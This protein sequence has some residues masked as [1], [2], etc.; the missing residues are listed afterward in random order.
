MIIQV[1]KVSENSGFC[2]EYFK[3]IENGN[4]YA[5]QEEFGGVFKWYTTTKQGEPNSPLR[6]D[7]TIEIVGNWED[8]QARQEAE[9]DK[10]L[11]EIRS[12]V[13]K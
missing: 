3:N 1:K 2:R 4:V 10:L 7:I 13:S 12:K 6:D 8:E 9:F 11:E 5:R